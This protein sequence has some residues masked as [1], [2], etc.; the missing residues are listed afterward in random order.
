M[1][2]ENDCYEISHDVFHTLVKIIKENGKSFIIFEPPFKIKNCLPVEFCFQVL[3]DVNQKGRQ[4]LV[5][6]S[7]D[8][9]QEHEI[10]IGNRFYFRL[11]LQVKY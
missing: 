3:S 1:K 2:K 9:Y 11:K 8:E 4:P 10:S 5:L 7:Q 6:G